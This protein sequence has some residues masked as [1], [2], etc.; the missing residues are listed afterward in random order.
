MEYLQYIKKMMKHN[1][2]V[3]DKYKMSINFSGTTRYGQS[4][5]K[6]TF[7]QRWIYSKCMYNSL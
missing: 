4:W 6:R 2:Y 7:T 1:V 3:L 5:I